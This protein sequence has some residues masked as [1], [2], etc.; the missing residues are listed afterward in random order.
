MIPIEED[1]IKSYE[2]YIRNDTNDSITEIDSTFPIRIIEKN[3]HNTLIVPYVIYKFID[4]IHIFVAIVISMDNDNIHYYLVSDTCE[5]LDIYIK[6]I[7]R[8]N[9]NDYDYIC[10][11]KRYSNDVYNVNFDCLEDFKETLDR[12]KAPP[13]YLSFFCDVF[14][15]QIET[16]CNMK[17]QM[18]NNLYL[19]DLLNDYIPIII[20]RIYSTY[21]NEI[22]RELTTKDEEIQLLNE[23]VKMLSTR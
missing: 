18:L 2:L 4:D 10:K 16:I 17:D 9:I 3:N 11:M 14:K 15:N 7:P 5:V 20:T 22:Y 19:N 23:R 21:K 1:K 8:S 13:S 6:K 12:Q